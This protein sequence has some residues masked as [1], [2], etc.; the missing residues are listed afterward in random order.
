M[1]IDTIYIIHCAVC[2]VYMI[3]APA[4]MYRPQDLLLFR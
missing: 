2:Y 4:A 1:S 3:H